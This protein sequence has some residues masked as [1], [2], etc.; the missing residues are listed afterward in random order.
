MI[1][2]FRSDG[3]LPD[4]VHLASEGEVVFGFGSSTARRRRLALRIGRWVSL[5]RQVRARRL[6][7][8]GSFVTA[9]AEPRDVDAVILLPLDF[10]AQVEAGLEP[11]FEIEQMI[12]TRRPE[13][14]FAAED[15][16]DWDEWVAFFQRTREADG[17]Q[18]GVVEIQL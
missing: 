8:D 1:P 5:A 14:L 2:P 16:E 15:D 10:Q 12:L 17:R 11:A 6:L 7:I 9:V 13:E 18:K 4:G 3:Y